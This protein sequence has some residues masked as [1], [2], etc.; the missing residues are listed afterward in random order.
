MRQGWLKEA[1]FAG[2]T[3]NGFKIGTVMSLG[4][5]WIRTSGCRLV[6]RGESMETIDFDN[7]LAVTSPETDEVTLPDFISH[8]AGKDYFYIVRCSNLCGQIERTL[9]AAV[10]VSIDS[11]GKLE[12]GKPNGVFGLAVKRR[13]DGQ[14]EF[15]WGYYPIEQK[16]DPK[17]MRIYT[18]AGTGEVNYQEPIAVVQYKGK[19][20]YQYKSEIPVNRRYRY[21]VRAAD[22]D[23]NEQRLSKAVEIE[24]SGR[25]VEAIE[26]VGVIGV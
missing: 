2:Q 8:E 23:G 6:Y 18:D 24:T 21:A 26:I 22:S 17:E 1:L 7:V 25:N 20:F 10:K 5:F 14:I 15:V 19:R 9:K 16:S 12:A 3:T 4:W 13:R 11:E